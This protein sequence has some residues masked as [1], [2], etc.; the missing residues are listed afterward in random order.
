[1]TSPTGAT[2]D[3]EHSQ[4]IADAAAAE[5]LAAHPAGKGA[6]I[7]VVIPAL[8]EVGSVADVIKT[9]P[10]TMCG[11]AVETLLIDDGSQDGT[12]KA[13][14]DA[15][16]LVCTVPINIGMGAALR[17]GYRLARAR[18]ARYIG[19][20]DAD[21]QFDPREL[22]TLMAP[23]I[24]D[25]A[26]FVNGSRRLGQS[27]TTDKVR[28]LGVVV[29][30]A[31]ISVLTGTRITDPANGLRAFKAEV[32]E[33]VQLR[34]TQYQTSELLIC[35]IANG[36]RVKEVPAT[37]YKRA[38]GESKK[39]RNW[40]YG[41]RFARVIATTWWAMRPTARLRAKGKGLW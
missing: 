28:G 29:F 16:A 21:A 15:G 4:E 33:A 18:G 8:N 31:L 41:L 6:P 17:L 40:I 20:A 1:M 10:E 22:P 14:A 2:R 26:D 30:G 39:G 36:F 23:L 37:M 32:T 5:F 24:A 27:Y 13:A 12:S 19:T 34:Q 38:A 7:A 35:T 11:L 25:E 9:V 3:P